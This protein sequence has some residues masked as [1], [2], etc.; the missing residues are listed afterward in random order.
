MFPRMRLSDTRRFGGVIGKPG[1]HRDFCTPCSSSPWHCSCR[2]TAAWACWQ[3]LIVEINP[4]DAHID[5][6]LACGSSFTLRLMYLDKRRLL[7]RS[8]RPLGALVAKLNPYGNTMYLYVR[9]PIQRLVRFLRRQYHV[10]TTQ[11][12][13]G[14][15]EV[16]TL[17]NILS[18]TELA[19]VVRTICVQL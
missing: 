8:I 16:R 2:N 5:K 15:R 4:W 17:T 13:G 7:R 19:L 11:L 3:I 10:D 9:V 1:Y 12:I 18:Q 6:V 14:R